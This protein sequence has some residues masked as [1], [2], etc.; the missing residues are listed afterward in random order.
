MNNL[1]ILIK[2]RSK[3]ELINY[4]EKRGKKISEKDI[5]SLKKS[6]KLKNQVKTNLTES[7]P[8]NIA[9]GLR[10]SPSAKAWRATTVNTSADASIGANSQRRGTHHRQG[11][12]IFNALDNPLSPLLFSSDEI[13]TRLEQQSANFATLPTDLN[14][15][16]H[17]RTFAS[18]IA[19]D[20]SFDPNDSLGFQD[21]TLTDIVATI[22]SNIPDYLIRIFNYFDTLPDG[23]DMKLQLQN[24]INDLKR[25][26]GAQ[27]NAMGEYNFFTNIT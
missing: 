9:G 5:E 23:N 6:C 15:Q 26:T 20:Q 13:S 3:Q 24:P 21:K 16:N 10:R 14:F 18:Q 25:F 27:K 22:N 7:Q 1:N 8:N 11:A 2:L 19:Y 12:G 4:F 17:L